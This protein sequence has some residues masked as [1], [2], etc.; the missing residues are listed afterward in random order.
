MVFMDTPTYHGMGFII[1]GL[2][3]IPKCRHF[4]VSSVI[5]RLCLES[6]VVQ[7]FG[8]PL[9]KL[10][11]CS[12]KCHHFNVNKCVNFTNIQPG[13]PIMLACRALGHTKTCSGS[14]TWFGVPNMLWRND[15]MSKLE[16]GLGCLTWDCPPHD[17]QGLSITIADVRCVAERTIKLIKSDI[18]RGLGVHVC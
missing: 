11:Q 17:M 7:V 10:M 4:L 18:C 12:S 1:E 3:Y 14:G 13:R 6:D 15:N 8:V 2:H 16:T 9:A 5:A